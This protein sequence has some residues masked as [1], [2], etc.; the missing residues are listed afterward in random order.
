MRDFVNARNQQMVENIYEVDNIA[1]RGKSLVH[2]Y[3]SEVDALRA[4]MNRII[5][6]NSRMLLDVDRGLAHTRAL[7]GMPGPERASTPRVDRPIDHDRDGG[8]PPPPPPS[9]RPPEGIEPPSDDS[10]KDNRRSNNYRRATVEDADGPRRDTPPHL[11]RSSQSRSSGFGRGVPSPRRETESID[12][13]NRRV[14]WEMRSN[15]R[16]SQA[17]REN[18]ALAAERVR[19]AREHEPQRSSQP[20]SREEPTRNHMPSASVGPKPK[21]FRVPG[22]PMILSSGPSGAH[23]FSA[24]PPTTVPY[25][26]HD[27][28]VPSSLVAPPGGVVAPNTTVVDYEGHRDVML[29]QICDNI[30][31]KVGQRLPALPEGVKHPKIDSPSKYAGENDHD[32]FYQWLDGYLT[33]LRAYNVCGPETDRTRVYYLR[34]YL[35][36][37][38]EEWF[39]QSVD[40]PTLGY[41]PT[42]METIC[43]MHRRFVHSST[44]AKAT[45][46]FNHC[47]YRVSEGVD[48]FYADLMKY[49]SRMVEPPTDYAVRLKLVDGLPSDMYRILTIDRNI[50]PEQCT[51]DEIITNV[52]QIEHALARV[53][54]R[55]RSEYR[56]SRDHRQPS[57]PRGHAGN[58][59]SESSRPREP[60]RSYSRDGRD[61][62]RSHDRRGSSRPGGHD[63]AGRR[64]YKD[65]RPPT[66]GPSALKPKDPNACYGCGQLGHFANDPK[67][68]MFGKPRPQRTRFHAQRLTDDDDQ[69][70]PPPEGDQWGGSQYDSEEERTL[71]P[72][73]TPSEGEESE[74]LRA[75]AMRSTKEEDD[76]IVLDL[77]AGRIEHT[78]S[79]RRKETTPDT[80]QPH[81]DKKL[82]AS[83]CALVEVNGLLAYTLFDSGSTTDSVSP[84][85]A[86]TSG[87]KRIH[88]EEQVT[89][90]LGCAGSRSKISY[91]TRVPI[92]YGGIQETMYFDI[93]NLDRYDCV[94]GTPFMNRHGIILDFERRV[95]VAGG[96]DCPA[97]TNDEDV[98]YRGRRKDRPRPI[99]RRKS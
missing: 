38:A 99:T 43:A 31:F 33:W 97:F 89:L 49:A 65:H 78:P 37:Q 20:H 8:V 66:P 55:D 62:S 19:F 39:T 21:A 69:P 1:Q 60:R 46:D 12:D 7:L 51:V 91:G 70:S 35:K 92:K 53:R 90:Q 36:G 5:S 6:D 2:E 47:H 52:R 48:A 28:V 86:F 75:M 71:S 58:R 45:R 25:E 85:F 40:N 56:E 81:R 16:A 27:P 80:V 77:R 3:A 98:E 30:L 63:S 22:E 68:P 83:L 79:V 26:P 73:P 95:I 9:H 93:V 87:A 24:Y 44:A 61:R 57:D 67:C 54:Q 29:R 34:P 94:I 10:S 64:E 23:K 14:D 59:A 15:E 13:Y 88:L 18:V 42:F 74:I 41:Q 32:T 50:N 4:R 11:T 82:Q 84:E 72:I 76:E 17:M 96:K